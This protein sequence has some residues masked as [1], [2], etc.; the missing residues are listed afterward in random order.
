M[1]RSHPSLFVSKHRD[2]SHPRVPLHEP[3]ELKGSQAV[4]YLCNFKHRPITKRYLAVRKNVKAAREEVPKASHKNLTDGAAISRNTT[5]PKASSLHLQAGPSTE[6]PEVICQQPG[7]MEKRG[8]H[9]PGRPAHIPRIRNVALSP[10]VCFLLGLGRGC[11]P[12]GEGEKQ[13]GEIPRS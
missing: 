11:S 9:S 10:R 7:R 8:G 4:I 3:T 2:N 12:T 13:A 1:L 6:G 5:A